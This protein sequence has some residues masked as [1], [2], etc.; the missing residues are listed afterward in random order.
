MANVD[1]T[2]GGMAID[3]SDVP[4]LGPV[5]NG[6]YE[7]SVVSAKPG[8]SNSGYPKI[9][10]AWKVEDGEYE[11]RQIFDTIAFHP[12]ALPMTKR[13]LLNMGFP[14][15]FSGEIETEDL[16]GITAHLVV[17][18]E[19]STQINPDTGEPYDPRNK[20]NRISGASG[21]LDSVL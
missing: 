3:F 5:P 9:D 2:E 7:A 15:D 10:V 12:N 11:G 17:T 21:G 14:E 6:T 19:Q 1:M 13:K 16:L 8:V 4:D 18:V 20:I